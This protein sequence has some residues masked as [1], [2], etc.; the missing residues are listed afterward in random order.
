M[1]VSI[2]LELSEMTYI[3]DAA[4]VVGLIQLLMYGPIGNGCSFRFVVVEL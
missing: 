1:E 4:N 2:D 3:L